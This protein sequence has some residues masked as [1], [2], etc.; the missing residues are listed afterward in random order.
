MRAAACILLRVDRTGDVEIHHGERG[1]D[2]DPVHPMACL[3][4]EPFD[5]YCPQSG[6][7][8]G[9]CLA[10]SAKPLQDLEALKRGE[11]DA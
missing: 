10:L 7:V 6:E 3:G 5:F 11:A 1:R 2:L 9:L 4:G 8:L